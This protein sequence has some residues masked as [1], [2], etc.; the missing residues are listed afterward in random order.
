LCAGGN[1][2]AAERK[3][4]GVHELKRGDDFS[5]KVTNWGATL[6]SVMLPDSKGNSTALLLV[7]EPGT[8]GV[9]DT[10]SSESQIVAFALQGTWTTLC[11]ATT[12][13]PNTW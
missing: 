13:S 11:S 9:R 12:P 10:H 6:M 4:V 7:E 2:A 3:T 5:I 1:A 8:S